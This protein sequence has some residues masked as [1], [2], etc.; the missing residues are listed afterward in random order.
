MYFEARAFIIND[1]LVPGVEVCDDMMPEAEEF[2]KYKSLNRCN[3]ATRYLNF[4]KYITLYRIISAMPE[5]I[6]G[7][8]I[9]HKPAINF[10]IIEFL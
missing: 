2:H 6:D 8:L 10:F 4:E 9:Q 1:N 3:R 7:R 5:T